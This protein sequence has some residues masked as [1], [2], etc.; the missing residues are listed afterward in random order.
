MSLVHG[1]TL[2]GLLAYGVVVWSVYE[3]LLGRTA[4]ADSI[5]T[6]GMVI[7][8]SLMILGLLLLLVV[9]PVHGRKEGHP[10]SEVYRSSQAI[11]M[12][13]LSLLAAA[14]IARY[15]ERILTAGCR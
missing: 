14:L 10:P 9:L 12:I 7:G 6:L 4:G 1:A 2:A 8:W 15:V 5:Y 11:V 3:L 13:G